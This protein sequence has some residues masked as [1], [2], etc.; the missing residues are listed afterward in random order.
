MTTD[1]MATFDEAKRLTETFHTEVVDWQKDNKPEELKSY[2]EL[3]DKS[4]MGTVYRNDQ[5]YYEKLSVFKSK[6]FG[7]R[8]YFLKMQSDHLD[9]VL[10]RNIELVLVYIDEQV[11]IL[12]SE[13]TVIRQRLKFYENIIFMISNFNYGDL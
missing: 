1:I 2:K 13:M 11:K 4:V 10:S 8:G 6:Y 9:R 5:A 3:N 7:L 12:D